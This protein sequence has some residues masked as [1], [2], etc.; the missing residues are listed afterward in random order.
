MSTYEGFNSEVSISLALYFEQK[1]QAIRKA[2]GEEKRIQRIAG[3]V[4]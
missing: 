3:E 4:A 1:Q 2:R